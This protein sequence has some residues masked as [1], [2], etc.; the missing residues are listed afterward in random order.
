MLKGHQPCSLSLPVPSLQKARPNRHGLLTEIKLQA[1][2][3]EEIII[4]KDNECIWYIQGQE[5]QRYKEKVKTHSSLSLCLV[6]VL[7]VIY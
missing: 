1:Y 4:T 5:E 3:I 7:K 6:L 2:N